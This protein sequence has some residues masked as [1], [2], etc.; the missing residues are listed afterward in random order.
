MFM[1]FKTLGEAIFELN[2]RC[3]EGRGLRELSDLAGKVNDAYSDYRKSM[4]KD[5]D[6]KVIFTEVMEFL[7]ERRDMN[8]DDMI[9][10]IKDKENALREWYAINECM[11]L[12]EAWFE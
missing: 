4:A 5:K 6:K 10:V 12:L 1:E 8:N 7:K 9:R 11:E 3:S 2:I